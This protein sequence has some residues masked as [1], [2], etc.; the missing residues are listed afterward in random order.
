VSFYSDPFMGTATGYNPQ[1]AGTLI[2]A[3]TAQADAA[4]RQGLLQFQNDQLAFQKAQQ[5]FTDTMSLGT[6]YGYMPGGNPFQFG[7]MPTVPQYIGFHA[8]TSGTFQPTGWAGQPTLQ[9]QGQQFQQ[10]QA[11]AAQQAQMTGMY[12]Q[13]IP[14][15]WLQQMP[16][17]D[18]LEAYMRQVNPN[19]DVAGAKA[20]VTRLVNETPQTFH[21]NYPLQQFTQADL[22]RIIGQFGGMP[23]TSTLAAQQQ[24]FTQGL[25]TAQFGLSVQQQQQQASQQYLD[26]LSRLQGPADYGQYLKVLG[27]TPQGLQGLVG[28]AAGRYLPGG[29]VS[30]AAPQPQTLQ[31]LVGAATG[32]GGGGQGANAAGQPPAAGQQPAAGAATPGGTNFQN[33]LSTAQG[34]PPPS[35]MAPQ[36]FNYMTPSQRQMVGSMY[37]NLGYAPMDINALYQ[38][39][40]PK[41]AAGSAAGNFRLV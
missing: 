38:Q 6:Q 40:L 35:Q 41:Y 31:N 8:D 39:S 22:Q 27:S 36:S 3:A 25:Q 19:W 11:Q 34:L 2:N 1:A 13:P 21:G 17:W 26:L 12:Q 16:T 32:F 28:A 15:Q 10:M 30:G 9:A 18:Q 20:M 33:F 7:Q 37:S 23:Q 24:A 5:A 29:G 14:E 4:Y